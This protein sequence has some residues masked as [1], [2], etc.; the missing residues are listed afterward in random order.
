MSTVSSVS[1]ASYSLKF[2]NKSLQYFKNKTKKYIVNNVFEISD[3][4]RYMY[5]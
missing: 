2:K 4:H 1:F 3:R 5:A